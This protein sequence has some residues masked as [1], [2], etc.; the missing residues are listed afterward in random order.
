M[1]VLSNN[2]GMTLVELILAAIILAMS[3]IMLASTFSSAMRILNRATLYKNVSA[4]AAETVELAAEQEPVENFT[5]DVGSQEKNGTL[6]ITYRKDNADGTTTMNG[7]YYLATVQQG[8]TNVGLTY[9]EFLPSNFSYDI[10][11]TPVGD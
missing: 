7:Q 5:Y 6:T 10:P 4:T 9:K 8:G 11:A 1:K 2:K 3:G